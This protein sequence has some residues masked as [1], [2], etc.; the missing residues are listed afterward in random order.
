[1]AL[2]VVLDDCAQRIIHLRANDIAEFVF[3]NTKKPGL[4]LIKTSADGTPLDGVTFRIAKIEDGSR[5]L[6]RTTQNGGEMAGGLGGNGGAVRTPQREGHAG[7]GSA[8]VL[9]RL[10]DDE[11]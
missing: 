2:A 9:I 11:S 1:M 7:Y 8:G 10:A 6:D 3:T 4:R 5:Y